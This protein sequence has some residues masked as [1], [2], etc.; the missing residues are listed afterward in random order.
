MKNRNKERVRGKNR[1]TWKHGE[2]EKE[3]N[4]INRESEKETS[5]RLTVLSPHVLARLS[6]ATDV[7]SLDRHCFLFRF[8]DTLLLL[9]HSLCA[10]ISNWKTDV[11]SKKRQDGASR[12][13]NAESQREEEEQ[14]K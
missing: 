8:L 9:L 2:R 10:A 7:Q 13:R 14:E 12:R 6:L 1:K 4:R 5:K 3:G 11:C